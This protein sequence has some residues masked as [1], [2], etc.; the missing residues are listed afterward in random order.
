MPEPEK[1]ENAREEI[2]AEE[3][4]KGKIGDLERKRTW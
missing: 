2:G 3:E 4:A 1:E